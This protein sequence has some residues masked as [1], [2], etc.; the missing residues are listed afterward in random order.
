MTVNHHGNRD[1]TNLDYLQ[2]LKPRV[3]VQEVWSSDHPG[4]EVLKRLTSQWVYSQERDLFATNMLE[5]NKL[6]IG[7]ELTNAYRA[8]EG[9]IVIQVEPGGNQYVVHVLNHKSP[10]RELLKTFGPYQ[11]K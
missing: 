9:H 1:G 11:S 7:P 10:S 8:Y 4:H 3:I 6:V 2:Q 5:A